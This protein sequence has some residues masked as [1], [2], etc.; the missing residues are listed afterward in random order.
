MSRTLMRV[1]MM[2]V[3]LFVVGGLGSVDVLQAK[4]N[5]QRPPQVMPSGFE[6]TDSLLRD[7]ER[8]EKGAASLGVDRREQP[9]HER[10]LSALPA[11]RGGPTPRSTCRSTWDHQGPGRQSTLYDTGWKQLAYIFDWNTSC[12]WKDLRDQMTAH[13]ARPRE[14][15]QDRAGPRALG[16][17]PASSS[18]FPNAVRL[19]PEGRAEADRFLPRTIRSTS[20]AGTSAP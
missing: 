1:V 7:V 17:L 19:H 18:E 10:A 9:V 20:T 4:P 8:A 2:S 11:G 3:F 5:N 15:H 12:C 14:G 16:P 13:R 6:S